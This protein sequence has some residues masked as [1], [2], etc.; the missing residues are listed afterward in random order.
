MQSLKQAWYIEFFRSSGTSVLTAI[1]TLFICILSYSFWVTPELMIRL[2]PNLDSLSSD[3]SELLTKNILQL[4]N[5][6]HP[7]PSVYIVGNSTLKEG[8]DFDALKS[9]LHTG[10]NSVRVVDLLSGGQS[11]LDALAIVDNLPKNAQGIVV[12]GHSMRSSIMTNLKIEIAKTGA[13]LGFRSNAVRD[14]LIGSGHV[15]SRQYGLYSLD[16]FGY[17][18]P[19]LLKYYTHQL[20]SKISTNTNLVKSKHV[21]SPDELEIDEAYFMNEI[22]PIFKSYLDQLE[23][24]RDVLIKI[25]SLVEERER[26]NLMLI[27][28]PL[29]PSVINNQLGRD[30]HLN[31]LEN[32]RAF[33]NLHELRYYNTVEKANLS[34]R[35]FRD[36]HHLF[37][38]NAI[39]RHSASVASAIS[40]ALN[41]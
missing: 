27:E 8:L 12:L 3:Y 21:M 36:V 7:P 14:F 17:A 2:A 26:L 28:T 37:D 35:D 34:A 18:A 13:N 22:E 25:K 24:G 29:N 20:T 39:F 6:T 31:Y 19:R 30:F 11:L 9:I 4:Q 41:E 10:A 32:F 38:T 40:D 1:A 15:P 16:S 33:S 23:L 5:Q